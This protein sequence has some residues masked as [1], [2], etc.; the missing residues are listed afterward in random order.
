MYRKSVRVLRVEE[1]R[2]RC[3]AMRAAK[4]RKRMALGQ[5]MV[6]VGWLTTGGCLGEHRV[7]LL[8]YPDGLH[9][10]VSVDGVPRKARTMR[11]VARCVALMLWGKM[12]H[13]QERSVA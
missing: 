1:K 4:E 12:A 10:A 8:A 7:E 3:A 6:P 5:A 9:L 2:R 11:G 13:G